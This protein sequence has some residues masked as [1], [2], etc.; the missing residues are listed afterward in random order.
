MPDKPA[1]MGFFADTPN[2]F[3]HMGLFIKYVGILIFGLKNFMDPKS[4]SLILLL[5]HF[6]FWLWNIRK[7][8]NCIS[9]G[10]SE[11]LAS[12]KTNIKMGKNVPQTTRNFC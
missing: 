12:Q 11:N 8:C 5:D 9:S 6:M 3:S 10:L 2:F 7:V 1:G 4:T